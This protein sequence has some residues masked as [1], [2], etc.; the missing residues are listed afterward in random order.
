VPPN[1]AEVR[2]TFSKDMREF[3]WAWCSLGGVPS[4]PLKDIHWESDHRTI[5]AKTTVAPGKP[6]AVWINADTADCKS[7]RDATGHSAVP[8][9]LTI[10][11]A[12]K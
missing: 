8:Y 12:A 5:V 7:F 10:Q 2:A 6:Y 11:T 9:L 3:G 1:L 4:P